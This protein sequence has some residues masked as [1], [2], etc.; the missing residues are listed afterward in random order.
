MGARSDT[1]A[2][3][4]RQNRVDPMGN[5]IATSERGVW[6]GNRGG[7]L[8]DEHERIRRTHA[9]RQW[10]YC[11]LDFKG[12]RREL[13]QPGK[14]T[15]LFFLDEPTA[16]AA[17]HRPCAE[18]QRARFNELKA[19]WPEASDSLRADDI[20]RRLHPERIDQAKAKVTYDARLADLPDGAM[21]LTENEPSLLWKGRLH[22]WTPAGYRES[23]P[24]TPAEQVAV[25]TPRSLIAV[26][27]SG[28]EVQTALD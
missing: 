25:L 5:L 26:L 21:V 24:A 12:R 4:P 16:L 3:S 11:L 23:H 15:E 2:V 1:V 22:R 18:C 19:L 17:G 7:A 10:I 27:A 9:S 13:M 28:F 14:Y 6:L 8:H 20:D